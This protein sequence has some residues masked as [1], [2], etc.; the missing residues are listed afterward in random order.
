MLDTREIDNILNEFL[1]PFDATAFA[2]TDFSYY[3]ASSR[4]EYAFVTSERMDKLFMANA[5][6]LGLEVEVD[7]FLLAFMHELGHH[8][9]LD[10]IDDA[11]Y[12][13]SAD[14]KETLGTTDED[15][16][17]YYN[18]PDELAAT[19]W[20]IN[21]INNHREEIAELWNR[22]KVAIANFYATNNIH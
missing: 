18:L 17:T 1:E 10:N 13:Y 4:I 3:Y 15:C 19:R 14:I 5:I 22:L 11:D 7:T 20:A 9:T 12:N 21:Y 6:T 16:L 2:G 8:E